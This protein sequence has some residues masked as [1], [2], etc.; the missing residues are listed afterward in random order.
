MDWA[1]GQQSLFPSQMWT[2]AKWGGSATF[3]VGTAA[4]LGR[5]GLARARSPQ[6][7]PH[8]PLRNK[9]IERKG[10]PVQSDIKRFQSGAPWARMLLAWDINQTHFTPVFVRVFVSLTQPHSLD[11]IKTQFPLLFNL[12]GLA[13][14]IKRLQTKSPICETLLNS[15]CY[16]AYLYSIKLIRNESAD[17]LWIKQW[18]VS[19]PLHTSCFLLREHLCKMIMFIFIQLEFSKSGMHKLL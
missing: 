19:A 3:C 5:S 7:S 2:A 12:W 14:R 15:S 13:G 1:T 9:A 4:P 11:L 17:P 6:L 16:A 18:G 8:C 10:F